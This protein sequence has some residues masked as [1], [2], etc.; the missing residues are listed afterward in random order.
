M[1]E[2]QVIHLVRLVDDLL[3]VSRI[4]A[5]KVHLD[6]EPI[7]VSSFIQRAVEE[8]EPTI[9]AGGHELM[10]TLPARQIVVNGDLVRLSQVVSNLLSNAAKYTEKPSRIWLTVEHSGDEAV[11]RV[12]DEGA[13]MEPEFIARMFNLFVQADTTLSRSRGG[14]GVGL[15]LVRRLVELHGGTVSATSPGISQ[16]SEFVMRLPISTETLSPSR[17]RIYSPTE[18]T[19]HEGRRIL[20][21]DDN[22]DAAT[23]VGSLLKMWGH[24]VQTAYNGPDALSMARTFRPQIVLLD[25]GMPGMSGYD[26]AKQLRSE[27]EFRGVIITALTG[28]GQ[29][30]DRRRSREAGFD[31]HLTKPPDPTALA[32]LLQSPETFTGDYR[33]N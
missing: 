22:V 18:L 5:G 19:K 24:E 7:E 13:G 32:A 31:H 23:S 21:V 20:V 28:Y 10:V 15:T 12:K 29:P 27:P 2:R 16:G 33:M 4:V 9:D 25:I 14:L 17:S 30:E 11:I 26:V 8:V 6:R 1:M 3:D